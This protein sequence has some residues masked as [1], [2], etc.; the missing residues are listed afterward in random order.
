MQ[1]LFTDNLPDLVI[2]SNTTITMAATYLGKSTRLTIGGQQYKY[3]SLTTLNFGTTGFNGLDTGA[4]AA[5]TLYYI[6]AVMQAGV[7]GL[8]ASLASS[9]TGPSGFTSFKE[10]AR[11]RTATGSAILDTIWKITEATPSQTGLMTSYV[12][13][14]KSTVKNLSGNYTIL[15][16]DGFDFFVLPNLGAD[17]TVTLPSVSVSKGRH[18]KFVKGGND[19]F[20]LRIAGTIDGN[21]DTTNVNVINKVYGSGTVYCDGSDFYWIEKI[22]EQ[23]E[24]TPT[25][26]AGTN[27]S[28]ITGNLSQFLRVGNRV[29]VAGHVNATTSAGS[30]T[31]SNFFVPVPLS[32]N[33]TAQNE[34]LGSGARDT[35]GGTALVGA[36]QIFGDIANDRAQMQ[37]NAAEAAPRNMWFTFVYVIK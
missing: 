23:G 11:A 9:A 33:M 4:I 7:P 21:N 34:L 31:T 14:V 5:N 8:I 6:Y 22:T 15:E 25:A 19:A 3:S 12:P 17:A 20:K 28:S 1:K 36:I 35:L 37:F 27:I 18:F 30:N 16:N 10:V 2:A 32:T 24:Y 13:I 29:T 26:I